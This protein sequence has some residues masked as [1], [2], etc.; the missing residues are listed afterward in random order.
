MESGTHGQPPL[1]CLSWV[2]LLL[3]VAAL[4]FA[5]PSPAACDTVR[6]G[7]SQRVHTTP[8]GKPATKTKLPATPVKGAPLPVKPSRKAPPAAKSSRKP[9]FTANPAPILDTRALLNTPLDTSPNGLEVP[10]APTGA[11]R[12]HTFAIRPV[13]RPAVDIVTPKDAVSRAPKEFDAA[14]PGLKAT[15]RTNEGIDITGVINAPG[16]SQ[17]TKSLPALE[18]EAPAGTSAGVLLQKTF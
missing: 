1:R 10:A 11:E 5:V 12:P 8:G 14:A 13:M 3:G 17:G 7:G 16:S 6:Q 4:L 2:G 15:L 18:R 9:R